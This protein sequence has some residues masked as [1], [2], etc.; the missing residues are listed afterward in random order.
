[1]ALFLDPEPLLEVRNPRI[2]ALAHRLRGA[3]TDP[4]VALAREVPNVRGFLVWSRFP[5]WTLTP[6]P[7]GTQVTV[8]DMRFAGQTPARF[9]ASTIVPNTNAAD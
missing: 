3:D 1:M 7:G 6:A 2:A 4:R 9:E 5:F 8:S